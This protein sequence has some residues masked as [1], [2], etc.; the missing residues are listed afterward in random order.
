MLKLFT[1]MQRVATPLLSQTS[2]NTDN[3]ACVCLPTLLPFFT[4]IQY[5]C[6][7]LKINYFKMNVWD[8]WRAKKYTVRSK[9][10]V[11]YEVNV[12][13]NGRYNENIFFIKRHF[14]SVL[15]FLNFKLSSINFSDVGAAMRYSGYKELVSHCIFIAWNPQVYC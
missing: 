5:S 4:I 3:H 1:A 13:G 9:E 15:H 7:I 8:Q 10:E 11:C 12:I 14:Y 6:S 2:S